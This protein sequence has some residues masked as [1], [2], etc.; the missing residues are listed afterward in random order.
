MLYHEITFIKSHYIRKWFLIGFIF[1][2]IS[3]SFCQLGN[4]YI[5]L[6]T[7]QINHSTYI[8]N[9]ISPNI[10]S[11]VQIRSIKFDGG[12]TVPLGIYSIIS[13]KDTITEDS[14]LIKNFFNWK[15]GDYLYREISLG[16]RNTFENVN[17][18]EILALGKSFAGKRG[19]SGPSNDYKGNILQNYL[20]N[21]KREKEYT[22]LNTSFF[23]HLEN[24]G[25]PFNNKTNSLLL[26]FLF[27]GQYI[28]YPS[29]SF[30]LLPALPLICKYSSDLKSLG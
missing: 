21:F 4:N 3:L 23:Y 30:L 16:N 24:L 13:F 27:K 25:L 26:S 12:L 1:F 15:Q 14:T 2:S 7:D 17:Q 19:L 18:I 11:D 29:L 8:S 5:F 9:D 28:T 6:Y 20:I 10:F 22:K